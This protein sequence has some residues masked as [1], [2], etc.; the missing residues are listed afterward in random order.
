MVTPQ[1]LEKIRKE[2]IL[3]GRDNRYKVEGYSFVLQGLNFYYVKTGEKR[4]FTG[5]E[6]ARGFIEFAHK[7]YGPTACDVLKSWG[8]HTT[9]DLGHI[10]YNLI[11]IKL[12]SKNEKDALEDFF[13]VI[14]IKDYLEKK[15]NYRIDKTYIKRVKGA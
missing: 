4:H 10:V 11:E 3:S 2:I 12:I 13:N 8:I 6:L 7:Q 1:V 5:N 15:D 14:D 9:D